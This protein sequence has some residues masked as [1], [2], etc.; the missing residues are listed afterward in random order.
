MVFVLKVW[1]KS[2]LCCNWESKQ[3]LLQVNCVLFSLLKPY[4]FLASC[5]P[6]SI[7]IHLICFPNPESSH[8]Q[9]NLT[10]KSGLL[11]TKQQPVC[12]RKNGVRSLQHPTQF[13]LIFWAD[14]VTQCQNLA[15]RTERDVWCSTCGAAFG[16]ARFKTNLRAL[17]SL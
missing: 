15:E 3:D 17:S 16:Q 9:F 13:S 11:S 8:V 12:T 1:C 4:L 5:R 14:L 6:S 10:N 2:G 7:V